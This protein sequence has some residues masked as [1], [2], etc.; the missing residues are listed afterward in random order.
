MDVRILNRY[1]Y[2]YYYYYYFEL[3]RNYIKKGSFLPIIFIL[4]I[5]VSNLGS[6]ILFSNKFSQYWAD[7]VRCFILMIN[8]ISLF[9]KILVPCLVCV[10][11][12]VTELCEALQDRISG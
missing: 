7:D 4:F 12:G 9:Y 10:S 3:E 5:K 1:Y 6:S 11:D 8:K 2:Y